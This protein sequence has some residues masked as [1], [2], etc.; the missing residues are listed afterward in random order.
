[1]IAYISNN[2]RFLIAAMLLV[3]GVPFA[4]GLVDYDS[5]DPSEKDLNE[6]KSFALERPSGGSFGKDSKYKYYGNGEVIDVV[7]VEN[8][9]SG[10]ARSR[11][12][13]DI[14]YYVLEDLYIGNAEAKVEADLI[15][16][17]KY[18]EGE[19]FVVRQAMLLGRDMDTFGSP[20]RPYEFRGITPVKVLPEEEIANSEIMEDRLK[21]AEIVKVRLLRPL[22]FLRDAIANGVL[23]ESQVRL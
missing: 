18:S 13:Y 6:M 17:K 8:H 9:T 7:S 10:A 16:T 20:K 5:Y 19:S 21:K 12:V 2:S 4:M 23:K 3:V 15:F 14:K 1:M 22:S 11:V